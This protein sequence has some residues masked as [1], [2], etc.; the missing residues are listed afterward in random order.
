MSAAS[1]TDHRLSKLS[2]P[3]H[4][5]H[6]GWHADDRPH[7]RRTEMLVGTSRGR[8]NVSQRSPDHLL[9]APF[10]STRPRPEALPPSRGE[11]QYTPPDHR[12]APSTAL[13]A[14]TE[15]QCRRPGRKPR[16]LPACDS[17]ADQWA[18]HRRRSP[19]RE[20]NLGLDAPDAGPGAAWPDGRSAIAADQRRFRTFDRRQS[21]GRVRR[22]AEQPVT[23]FL[24]HAGHRCGAAAS[25][26]ALDGAGVS[27]MR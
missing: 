2:R 26:R 14:Q 23:A 13:Q 24:S 19:R 3:S 7:R 9:K 20:M 27:R 6:P 10:P 16:G 21:P 25:A 15:G 22:H 12:R 17:G 18:R 11:R 5:S 1:F 8:C 4:I